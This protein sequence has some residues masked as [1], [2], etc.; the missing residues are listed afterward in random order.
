MNHKG[1]PWPKGVKNGGKRTARPGKKI[2]RPTRAEAEAKKMGT[3]LALKYLQSYMKP[4][5]DTYLALAIGKQTGKVRRKLD[6]ATCRHYVER[7]VPPAPKTITLQTEHTAEDF[8]EK[9]VKEEAEK[10]AKEGKN[11]LED[12]SEKETVH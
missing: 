10:K 6:P 4:V 2:G 9:F 11:L 7:I 12:K 8:Y 5:L 3:E 1:N